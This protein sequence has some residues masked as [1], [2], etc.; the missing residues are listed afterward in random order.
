M[1][2]SIY[3][4][5]F[6]TN[7]QI[8]LFMDHKQQNTAALFNNLTA[9][10]KIIGTIV[11]DSDIRLDGTLEGDLQCAG[12]VVIGEKGF[13][14]GN[15]NCQNADIHGRLEGKIDVKQQLEL[16][17]ASNLQGEVKTQSLIVEPGAIFNGTCSMGKPVAI[18]PV[19]PQA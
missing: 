12:K 13:I 11:A 5:N 4:T 9:G 18:A 19:K 6:A 15:V 16:R 3:F 8:R 14:K 2:I 17:S 7:L 10:S 1:H